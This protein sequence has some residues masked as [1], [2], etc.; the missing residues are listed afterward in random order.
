MRTAV[1]RIRSARRGSRDRRPA[2]RC[3]E[4]RS[5]PRGYR[6][7]GPGPRSPRPARPPFGTGRGLGR[8]L[9]PLGHPGE[10]S[11]ACSAF[12]LASSDLRAAAAAAS[13]GLPGR[14]GRLLHGPLRLLDRLL[15]F[16]GQAL[17]LLGGLLQLLGRLPNL[18]CVLHGLCH[19]G[20]DCGRLGR[21]LP[22]LGGALGLGLGDGLL[23]ALGPTA[24]PVVGRRLA[25]LVRLVLTVLLVVLVVCRCGRGLR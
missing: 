24:G 2:P 14:L 19:L 15:G 7:D 1:V 4:L 20:H 18:G 9:G 23:G 25:G 8:V 10:A 22:C 5:T 3:G 11:A 21:L 6:P 16:V 13:F 12:R 17:G